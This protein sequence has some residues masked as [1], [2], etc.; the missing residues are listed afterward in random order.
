MT[1]AE[2]RD[3]LLTAGFSGAQTVAVAGTLV[4][5]RATADAR[6]L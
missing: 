1:V 5:H 2:Q 6:L 4:L 3:A